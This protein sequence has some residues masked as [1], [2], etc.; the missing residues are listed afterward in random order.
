MDSERCV[1]GRDETA[2]AGTSVPA[3][4][5]YRNMLRGFHETALSTTSRAPGT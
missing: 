1:K 2:M 3:I 4:A 5:L